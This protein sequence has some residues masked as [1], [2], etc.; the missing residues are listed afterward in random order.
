MYNLQV[1]KD[2]LRT[3]GLIGDYCDASFIRND[4]Y[5]Q[6]N[7]NALELVLYFDEVEVCDALAS[8]RGERKLGMLILYCH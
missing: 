1:L 2:H 6:D 3:D 5:L 7:E 4:P 8:H